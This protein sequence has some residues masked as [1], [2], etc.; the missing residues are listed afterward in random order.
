M[1]CL[2]YWEWTWCYSLHRKT[3]FDYLSLPSLSLSAR[4]PWLYL[5]QWDESPSPRLQH[6]SRRE[7]DPLWMG[8][9]TLPS[10][11]V[12]ASQFPPVEAFEFGTSLILIPL[13]C[14]LKNHVIIGSTLLRGRFLIINLIKI[15]VEWPQTM[16]EGSIY[17]GANF[18]F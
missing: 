16:G 2:T 18:D 6:H 12:G 1:R 9:P 7:T 8:K 17:R 10:T 14:G 5:N 4:P 15:C 11:W 13:L 3:H